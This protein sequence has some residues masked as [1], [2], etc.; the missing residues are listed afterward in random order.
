MWRRDRSPDFEKAEWSVDGDD[1]R[2]GRVKKA[3]R[4][5]SLALA[6]A[7]CGKDDGGT[8]PTPSTGGSTGASK[9]GGSEQTSVGAGGSSVVGGNGGAMGAG[10]ATVGAGGSAPSGAGESGAVDAGGDTGLRGA[11]DAT[12]GAQG[13]GGAGAMDAAPI[14]DAT[15][16]VD[17]A[18]PGGSI[19]GFAITS[20]AFTKS[21]ADLLIPKSACSPIDM[22]PALMFAGVP[23][24]AKSLAITFVDKQIDA[25][26]WVVWDI[27]PDAKGLPAN[28]S[29]T[30]HPMELPTSTQRGSLGRTGYAGPGTDQLR[31]YEFTLYAL[32]TDKLPGT[33]GIDTVA[34]RNKA[35]AAHTVQKS[36]VLAAKGKLGGP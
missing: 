10:G 3:F 12:G 4:I 25:V 2:H 31:V 20:D 24:T 14:A 26:K 22:S 34:L 5:A 23:A 6:L 30:Q 21:G 9:G 29:K 33:E 1:A 27:P 17:S 8:P 19:A 16:P 11:G 32:D 36:T 13:A 35:I 28:L 18:T 7:A 15:P